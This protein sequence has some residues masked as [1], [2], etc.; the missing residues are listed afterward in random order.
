[1]LHIVHNRGGSVGVDREML[2]HRLRQR[3]VEVGVQIAAAGV[4][5]STLLLSALL[6]S[7]LLLSTPLLSALRLGAFFLC[8]LHLPFIFEIDGMQP[9]PVD[10]V[11]FL[12]RFDTQA[13]KGA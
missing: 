8:D 12:E 11:S 10:Y 4:V 1:M 13:R 2:M 3:T 7:A 9:Q 6:L 5:R